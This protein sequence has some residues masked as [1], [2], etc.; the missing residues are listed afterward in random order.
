VVKQRSPKPFKIIRR[1]VQ[2][3]EQTIHD[4]LQRSHGGKVI[5]TAFIERLNATFRQRISSLTRRSRQAARQQTTLHASMY[6][7][8]TVYN[9]CVAH[10]SLRLPIWLS[11][12]RKH[13]V[14]RTPAMATGLTDHI[15]AIEEVMTFKIA[16][17]PYVP[18]K[19]RGRPPKKRNLEAIS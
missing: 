17:S 6:L 8:G 10:H 4:L 7:V 16:P 3:S 1:I 13:W 5:N 9:F 18:P 14:Q 11:E 19:P 12:R 15:W 2:G